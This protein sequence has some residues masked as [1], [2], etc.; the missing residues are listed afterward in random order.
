MIL[1][2][3]AVYFCVYVELHN[4]LVKVSVQDS[5]S[6]TDTPT[7]GLVTMKLAN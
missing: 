4:G 5:F 2:C 3:F 7:F 1:C 6:S